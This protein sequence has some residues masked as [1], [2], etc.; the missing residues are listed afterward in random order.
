MLS[1]YIFSFNVMNMY[2][3]K[4]RANNTTHHVANKTKTF[5]HKHWVKRW[6]IGSKRLMTDEQLQWKHIYTLT[7][8]TQLYALE[9]IYI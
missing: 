6:Q 4:R 2:N 8:D 3:D 5:K 9:Y 7:F 1:E